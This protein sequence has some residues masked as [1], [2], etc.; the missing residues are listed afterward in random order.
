MQYP[1]VQRP[2]ILEFEGAQRMSDAL[3]RIRDAVCIVVGRIDAPL[4]PCLMVLYMP[5]AIEHRVTHIHIRRSHVDFARRAACSVGK[6][7]SSHAL[8]KL[9]VSQRGRSRFGLF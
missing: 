8:E 5:D 3:D 2:M 9:Q 7:A 4:G 6:L 1:V